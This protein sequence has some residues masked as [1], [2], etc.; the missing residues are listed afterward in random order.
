[1]N[2]HPYQVD[3][4]VG[5]F[6]FETHSVKEGEEIRDNTAEFVFPG[7]SGKEWYRTS[8][9]KEIA[10]VYGS[11]EDSYRKTANLINR[12]R[13]QEGGT[14][15]R[16]LKDN[17]E[18]EG[19]KIIDFVEYKVKK[20][21][22]EKK[23]TDEGL[24]E[25][26][27]EEYKVNGSTELAEEKVREAIK[28]C[29]REYGGVD[30]DLGSN[31]VLYEDPERSVHISIDDVG[32]K[33]QKES[34]GK[35]DAG[36]KGKSPQKYVHNTIVHIE[37][38]KSSYVLNGYGVVNVLRILVAFLLHNDLLRDRLQFFIDGQ[39]TLKIAIL[40]A[41]SWHRDIGIIL[42]WHHLEKK[43]KEKLSLGMKGYKIRNEVLSKIIPVLWHGLADKAI[44]MLNG[45]DE[46]L[47]KNKGA[48]EELVGYI[49][50]NKRD[51]PCYAVRK[52]LGLRNSS[53][54]GEKMNDL[55][56]SK[57]QKHNGMSWSKPGSV[58]LAS[59]T[60]MVRNNETKRWFEEG[61]IELKLAA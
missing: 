16:T 5:R 57:R 14:P 20:I 2:S 35:R 27:G 7:L 31:P 37:K 50:R 60:A 18:Q 26:S 29:E 59:I 58:T 41:F 47:V 56:V 36:D 33:G 46:D 55:V 9:F 23:F 8:G 44:K 13:H 45:L 10:I 12:I 32:V 3:G 25:E 17:T 38:G 54:I 40:K 21:L 34:R 48:I 51:I 28:G 52:K 61:K 22:K 24:P 49:E 39:K 42:D 19:Q 43:C 6:K 11:T 30:S 53:N 4:E 1:M 15:S